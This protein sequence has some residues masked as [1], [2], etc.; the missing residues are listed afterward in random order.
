MLL[1]FIPTRH[2]LRHIDGPWDIL[3]AAICGLRVIMRRNNNVRDSCSQ[4]LHRIID[5]FVHTAEALK[6]E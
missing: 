5:V 3:T 1:L 4:H 2:T 6:I